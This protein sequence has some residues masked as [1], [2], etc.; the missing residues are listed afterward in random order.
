MRMASLIVGKESASNA[1]DPGSIPGSGRSAREGTGYPLQSLAWRIP[2]TVQSMGSQGS[3]SWTQ[4]SDFHVTWLIR[5]V[6]QQK[7]TK[8]C[9]AIIFQLKN[10]Q[11]GFN[12]S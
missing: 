1:G 8:H 7:L 12:L 10:K 4:L 5:V 9:R 2:R 11:T 6:V 3:Q